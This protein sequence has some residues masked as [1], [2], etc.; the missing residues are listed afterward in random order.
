MADGIKQKMAKNRD[1]NLGTGT[2]VTRGGYGYD[3]D[4]LVCFVTA[5]VSFEAGT[6]I[7]RT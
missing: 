1:L 6:S 7:L 2:G 4:F 5:S 3:Y